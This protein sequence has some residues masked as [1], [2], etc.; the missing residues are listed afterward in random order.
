MAALP[1]VDDV[2]PRPAV[3]RRQDRVPAGRRRRFLSRHR[4]RDEAPVESNGRRETVP[5]DPER[6]RAG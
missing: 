4:D 6:R 2:E 1:V 3:D 5:A